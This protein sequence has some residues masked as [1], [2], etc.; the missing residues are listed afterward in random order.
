[1]DK[2]YY[3]PFI[4]NELSPKKSLGINDAPEIEYKYSTNRFP[5]PQ[6]SAIEKYSG[7]AGKGK[8][9]TV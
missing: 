2:A 9:Y 4:N 5:I 1:M 6:P 3:F 8:K 7:R